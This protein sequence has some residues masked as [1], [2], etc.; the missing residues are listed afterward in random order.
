MKSE[1]FEK[2]HFWAS[3]T[4]FVFEALPRRSFVRLGSVGPQT[5][6]E[7]NFLA[8]FRIFFFEVPFL[9]EIG[10][11]VV[12]KMGFSHFS[13]QAQIGEILDMRMFQI[14]GPNPGRC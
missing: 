9:D 5:R 8:S 13:G 12:L 3:G 1:V 6:L 14:L 10:F 11:E 2:G 4:T 7:N